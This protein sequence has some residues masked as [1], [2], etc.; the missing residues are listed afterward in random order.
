MLGA[1]EL[2]PDF[3]L[4][5]DNSMYVYF[6]TDRV[7]ITQLKVTLVESNLARS[8]AVLANADP[9]KV[10]RE[11]VEAQLKR[12][13]TVI[14]RDASGQTEF[15][16]GLL[17]IGDRPYHPFNVDSELPILANER[18]EIHRNQQ[19]FI[20]AFKVEGNSHA[21]GLA[22]SVD[23]APGVTVSVISATQGQQ[24]IDRYVHTPGTVS[25][26]EPPRYTQNVSF[27]S[28]FRQTIP[29]PEGSYY[30][31]IQQLANQGIPPTAN[32]GDDRA[33]KVDYLV[34]LADA[35]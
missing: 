34:Q 7:D 10:G 30:L 28:L 19:D 29:V 25:L 8:T 3:Q 12:G 2:L 24:L 32:A 31:L 5:P 21:L 6:R 17:S 18:T 27:G 1:V 14:R 26:T 22:I 16:P 15:G 23:G 35:P 9:E 20:G 4:A 11:I 13:F 33:A